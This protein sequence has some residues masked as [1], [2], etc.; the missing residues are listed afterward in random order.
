MTNDISACLGW[1]LRYKVCKICVTPSFH[2]FLLPTTKTKV[3]KSHVKALRPSKAAAK[4]TMSVSLLCR[5][6]EIRCLTIHV[7][8]CP[9]PRPLQS[10]SKA[11]NRKTICIKTYL[12][13]VTE[14]TA[15][16]SHA[17][18]SPAAL[19]VM[20]LSRSVVDTKNAEMSSALRLINA[21]L[22]LSKRQS[23]YSCVEDWWF[24]KVPGWSCCVWIVC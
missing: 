14:S 12:W 3:L 11:K 24:A 9:W 15:R 7:C 2:Y 17:L 20:W 8:F 22:A 18:E 5:A 10:L 23:A 16:P 6:V 19:Y 4:M 21:L 1:P 13:R